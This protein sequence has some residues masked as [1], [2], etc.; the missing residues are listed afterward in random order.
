MIAVV[1]RTLAFVLSAQQPPAAPAEDAPAW[2]APA[3]PAE[4][5][6]PAPPTVEAPPPEG[7]P[8]WPPPAPPPA[9][10]PPPGLAPPPPAAAVIASTP[11]H[12]RGGA[13]GVGLGLDILQAGPLEVVSHGASSNG[14][15][16]GLVAA[17]VELG[18]HLSLRVPLE[19]GY[20]GSKN[21]G[22]A[23]VEQSSAFLEVA[24]APAIVYRFRDRQA[25]WV[26]YLGGG[27]KAGAF[28]FGRTLLGLAPNPPPAKEQEFQ[29]AG[30]A[31]EVLGGVLFTPVRW[32]SLRFAVDY[33]YIYVAH[34]SVHAF[35]ET[36]APRF[37]F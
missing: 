26:P 33:T 34:T 21:T 1:V 29:R 36:I 18:P 10:S 30:A 9:W 24:F 28:M 3:P 13:F 35:T 17:E 8:T 22:S 12:Q 11:R 6:P 2:P 14:F 20:A 19:I 32:F 25:R 31:P 15:L 5:A 27:V 23:G 4:A 16:I 7:A 37:S